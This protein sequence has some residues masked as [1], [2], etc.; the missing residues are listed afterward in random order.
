MRDVRIWRERDVA[1]SDTAGGVRCMFGTIST[2]PRFNFASPAEANKIPS[3]TPQHFASTGQMPSSAARGDE[4]EA[5]LLKPGSAEAGSSESE[6]EP[7]IGTEVQTGN[8]RCSMY[9]LVRHSRTR[10]KIRGRLVFTCAVLRACP[11]S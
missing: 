6:L 3:P 10:K 5:E 8:S 1:M 9:E 7:V 11:R 4:D 2:R